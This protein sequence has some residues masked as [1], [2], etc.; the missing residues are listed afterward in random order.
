MGRG[1]SL[2]IHDSSSR[3]MQLRELRPGG[4]CHSSEEEGTKENKS[5]CSCSGAESGRLQGGLE[6]VE[7]LKKKVKNWSGWTDKIIQREGDDVNVQK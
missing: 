1:Q 3:S 7:K 4:Q 6:S 5:V 2:K